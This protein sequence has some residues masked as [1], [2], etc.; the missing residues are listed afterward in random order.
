MR[1][2]KRRYEEKAPPRKRNSPAD[3]ARVTDWIKKHP[4][5]RRDY[6]ARYNEKNRELINTKSR[7]F[8]Q[9]ARRKKW[10]VVWER[11]KYKTDPKF[12]LNRRMRTQVRRGLR[13]GK[14]GRSWSKIVGYSRD[15]LASHLARQFKPGMSWQNFSK[16][17][18][19]HIVPVA[20][21]KFSSVDDDDFRRCWALTNLQ[22]LWADENHKKHARRTH[23]I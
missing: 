20:A 9:T 2:Y 22:P 18:I 14:G 16:W 12:A 8:R 4:G 3:K 19:D 6:A 21:F 7:A 23:L 10:M 5:R 13:D 17:H 1:V 11:L 15:E